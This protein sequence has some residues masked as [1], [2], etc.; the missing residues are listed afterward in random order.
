ML[1]TDPHWGNEWKNIAPSSAETPVYVYVKLFL[2][3]VVIR[4]NIHYYARL[5]KIIKFRKK[6]F[7]GHMI[8]G[9]WVFIIN[10]PSNKRNIF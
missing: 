8:Y 5:N 6:S 9:S 4:I 3:E 10:V 1:F 2:S 7:L